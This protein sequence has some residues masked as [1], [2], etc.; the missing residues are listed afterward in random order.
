M[1]S[2]YEE[3]TREAIHAFPFRKKAYLAWRDYHRTAYQAMEQEI[4]GRLAL[5]ED[6]R[7]VLAEVVRKWM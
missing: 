1:D 7:E 6:Q 4:A 2:A 3:R 5:T